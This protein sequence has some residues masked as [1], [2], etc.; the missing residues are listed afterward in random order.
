MGASSG[1]RYGV[2]P[3]VQIE[4]F[5]LQLRGGYSFNP[6]RR[7]GEPKG[8]VTF[9]FD[10]ADIFPK[11]QSASLAMGVLIEQLSLELLRMDQ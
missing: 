6:N 10:V 1:F 9:S 3:G 2:G 7:P 5:G 8:A 4:F 11:H